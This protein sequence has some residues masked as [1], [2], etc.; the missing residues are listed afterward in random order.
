VS[1]GAPFAGAIEQRL[2]QA[3]NKHEAGKS[4]NRQTAIGPSDLGFC[5]NKAALKVREVAPT[6]VPENPLEMLSWPA[7][8]GTAIH[9][10][11]EDVYPLAFEDVVLGSQHGKV[12]ATFPSGAQVSGTFDACVPSLNLLLDDKTKNGL[13]WQKRTG[14]SQNERFQAHTYA[15]GCLQEGLLDES[16]PVYVANVY[17]DRSGDEKRP[18]VIVEEFDP[19]L[20]V[21]V[22]EWVQDVIYAVQ[23]NEQ[24]SQDIPAERCAMLCEWFTA[25]RG[26]VLPDSDNPVLIEDEEI[27]TAM[28]VYDE[29]REAEKRAKADKAAAAARLAGVNGSDGEF[30]VRWTE[31]APSTGYSVGPRDGYLKV[32]VKRIKEKK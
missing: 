22:D 27:K 24:A 7:S 29:A 19:N 28:R 14:R 31:V 16:K 5:R 21:E 23:N 18:F 4:R 13:S 8:V 9:A 26:G 25:C 32:N 2:V 20:T 6:D 10:W 3:A 17:W 11:L 12:T 30:Q 15:L 1:D